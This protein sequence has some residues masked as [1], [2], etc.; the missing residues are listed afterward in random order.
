MTVISR[1]E[2]GARGYAVTRARYGDRKLNEW[3][4]KGGRKPDPTLLEILAMEREAK[5]A[6]RTK[7]RLSS[8]RRS[9]SA[10]DSTT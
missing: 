2:S 5:A 6:T 9:P 10:F 8:R 7:A 4:R 3:R 1:Q